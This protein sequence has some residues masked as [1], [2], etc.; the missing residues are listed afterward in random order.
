MTETLPILYLP[1][2]QLKQLPEYSRSLPTGTTIGKRWKR[3]NGT[4]TEPTWV[5]GEYKDHKDKKLVGIKWY[6]L[7]TT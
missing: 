2:N 4:H 5:I 1:K 7:I 6:R 3:N